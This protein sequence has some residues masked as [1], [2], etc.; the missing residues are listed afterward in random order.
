MKGEKA[1][2]RWHNRVRM[3][4]KKAKG[5]SINL[6]AGIKKEKW[7]LSEEYNRLDITPE[8]RNLSDF[9]KDMMQSISKQLNDIWDMEETR[10]RQRDRIIKE[11]DRNTKYF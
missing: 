1:I 8:T 4:R 6:E 11:G 2:D 7:E 3:F 9:E 5:W 10:G